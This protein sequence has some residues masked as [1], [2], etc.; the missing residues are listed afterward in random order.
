MHY[1]HSSVMLR[2]GLAT[3]LAV[4][5]CGSAFAA[6]GVYPRSKPGLVPASIS[7]VL[8]KDADLLAGEVPDWS[9]KI[10]IVPVG[11]GPAVKTW[12]FLPGA[13]EAAK[14]IHNNVVTWDGTKDDGSPAPSPAYYYAGITA[15]ASPVTNDA[16]IHLLWIDAPSNL[17]MPGINNN[18]NSPLYGRIYVTQKTNGLRVYEPDGT[19]LG[20]WSGGLAWGTASGPYTSCVDDDDNVWMSARSGTQLRTF[21]CIKSDLSGPIYGPISF[22]YY[23]RG[24]T[25]YG[26][27]DNIKILDSACATTGT[28][29]G[30]LQW[31]SGSGGAPY[32]PMNTWTCPGA[33]EA[34]ALAFQPGKLYYDSVAGKV[35]G[36]VPYRFI[37]VNAA[38]T[39]GVACYDIDWAGAT[40]PVKI[41]RNDTLTMA[42][43]VDIAPDGSTL[44]VTRNVVTDGQ[45]VGKISMANA[46]AGANFDQLYG[47][48]GVGV[49]TQLEY[50]KID[51]FG[52]VVSTG[53]G[54]T[55]AFEPNVGF[56]EPP[57]SAAASVAVINMPSPNAAG[58]RWDGDDSPVFVSGSFSLDPACIGQST[59]L[60]V[61][62]SDNNNNCGGGISDIGS[63]LATC[64]ALG[65]NNAPMNYQS[66]VGNQRTYALTGQ[67]QAGAS[68]GATSCSLQINDATP[69]VTP[70]TGNVPL[71]IKGGYITGVVANGE[72]SAP[73]ANVT[74]KATLG[75]DT[76]TAQ[77]DATGRYTINVT[78]GNGY[79]VTLD[80]AGPYSTTTPSEYNL[81]SDWPTNSAGLDWPKTV[82]V[83]PCATTADLNGRVWPLAATEVF[84]NWTGGAYMPG[85]RNVC[86]MGTVIRQPNIASVPQD[87][88]DGVYWI[89]DSRRASTWIACKIAYRAGDPLVKKGDRVVVTGLYDVTYGW[90][91]GSVTPASAGSVVILSSSN[92]LPTPRDLGYYQNNGAS[93][94]GGSAIIGNLI[95]GLYKIPG[96][97]VS[98]V[99][100]TTY[101]AQV[102]NCV[103]DLTLRPITISLETATSTGCPLPAVND[104][105]VITGVLDDIAI[106]ATLGAI[107]PGE[108]ADQA[109]VPL[110]HSI[111]EA[112]ALGDGAMKID[113]ATGGPGIVTSVDMFPTV[114]QW[115]CVEST[116]RSAGLRVNCSA[117]IP[118]PH[119]Q[120]GDQITYL[121]GNL[122]L[123]SGDRELV[124][125][126][127]AG[128][129]NMGAPENVPKPLG[130]TNLAV[131]SGYPVVTDRG[132]GCRTQGLLATLWGQVTRV[133]TAGVYLSVVWINDGTGAQNAS[134]DPGP[135]V[136]ITPAVGVKCYVGDAFAQPVEL[137]VGDYV[138]VSGIVGSEWVNDPTG[139]YRVRVLRMRPGDPVYF[140]PGDAFRVIADVP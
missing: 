4:C 48:A 73:A 30:Y 131:G 20:T 127:A 128:L 47:L 130:M 18:L 120:P 126:E 3:V 83:A 8:N 112:Q 23:D 63:V 32:T 74:V 49:P 58:I 72:T 79:S 116:D 68:A 69:G 65:W 70:G 24:G 110:V 59:T 60:T 38:G 108:P 26:P 82:D 88:F 124:L 77:T 28:I 89:A 84:Y 94:C 15:R 2:V 44:W 64:A 13:P 31:S 71:T 98:A 35:R 52:N 67:V 33:E 61:T 27:T 138:S 25:V 113:F 54:F 104:E 62:V 1:K 118:L 14:G 85:N 107:K 103:T 132:A 17:Y 37:N 50:M 100:T 111:G 34:D 87:G 105:L 40:A 56:Y 99:G 137:S 123:T 7:Y 21:W 29:T 19:Y 42:L 46:A 16:N 36:L 114:Q 140:T 93:A 5:F 39:G 109:T 22:P 43:S 11:G 55:E 95:G 135:P 136:V 102:P 51:G 129:T 117:F 66:C 6:I 121:K 91:A 92:P 97:I 80:T 86:V 133:E 10:E 12:R 139:G 122:R 75:A 90:R 81:Y 119:V 96:T 125:S 41:W 106:W 45:E 9:L 53:G 101:T 78:P 57:E 134:V 76:F 115:F